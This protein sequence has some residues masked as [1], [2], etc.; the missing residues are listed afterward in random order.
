MTVVVIFLYWYKWSVS[1]YEWFIFGPQ[2]LIIPN[3]QL[4]L[5]FI[6]FIVITRVLHYLSHLWLDACFALSLSLSLPL[7]LTF[8]E[9]MLLLCIYICTY[10][11]LLVYLSHPIYHPINIDLPCRAEGWKTTFLHGWC[12]ASPD[13]IYVYPIC[14]SH[15]HP[16]LGSFFIQSHPFW[17]KSSLSEM[18]GQTKSSSIVYQYWSFKLRC[19]LRPEHFRSLFILPKRIQCFAEIFWW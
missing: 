18:N 1:C 6:P 5:I 12:R 9:W 13:D 4:S 15:G 16:R 17:H 11:F 14:I 2:C 19:V 3:I 7:C 10:H 8:N